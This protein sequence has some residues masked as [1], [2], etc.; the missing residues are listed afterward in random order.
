MKKL[1]LLFTLIVFAVSANA[2]SIAT[3]SAPK[4]TTISNVVKMKNVAG[5]LYIETITKSY[6]KVDEYIFDEGENI[7]NRVLMYQ[8]M[9]KNEEKRELDE[10]LKW[11]R[12]YN[13]I[14]A[15]GYQIPTNKLQKVNALRSKK[16]KQ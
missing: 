14:V 6:R 3:V 13:D 15:S 11:Q 10:Q 4:D 8:A 9:R 12:I 5:Q 16:L 2:Q 7:E 1:F